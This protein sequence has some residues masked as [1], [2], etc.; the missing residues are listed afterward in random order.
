MVVS[1]PGRPRNIIVDFKSK[2]KNVKALLQKHSKDA[3][4]GEEEEEDLSIDRETWRAWMRSGTPITQQ[5]K[6]KMSDGDASFGLFCPPY[7]FL[8]KIVL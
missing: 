6:Q 8:E 3:K 7:L 4:T 2:Y 1:G 5:I